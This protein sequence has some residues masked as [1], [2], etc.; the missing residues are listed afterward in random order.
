MRRTLLDRHVGNDPFDCIFPLLLVFA[1]QVR[2][3]LEVFSLP[4]A[5][6]ERRHR[7]V[8]LRGNYM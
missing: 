7:N 4:W 6:S 2:T 8:L 5:C 1:V 3:E